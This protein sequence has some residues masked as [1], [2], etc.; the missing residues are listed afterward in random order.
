MIPKVTKP[1]VHELRPLTNHGYKLM[2]GVI[3]LCLDD[4]IKRNE[5]EKDV[6]GGFTE[7]ARIKNNLFIL[8]Y[9]I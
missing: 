9:C 6:Q 1:K 7:G 8:R 2:M 3:R 5:L 4:H